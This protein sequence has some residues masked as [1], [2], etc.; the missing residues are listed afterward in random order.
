[1]LALLARVVSLA[2]LGGVLV[3]VAWLAHTGYRV[4]TDSFVTPITLSP[5]SDVVLQTKLSMS[6]LVAERLRISARLDEIRSDLRA[7]D[8]ASTQ[9]EALRATAA[10]ALDFATA[11]STRHADAGSADLRTLEQ[12]KAKLAEMIGRQ[13]IAVGRARANVRA[14]LSTQSDLDREVQTLDQLRV[15]LLENERT[16]VASVTVQ[17]DAASAKRSLTGKGAHAPTPEMLLQQDQLVKVQ[18]ELV[19]I[20]AER[21]ARQSEQRHLDEEFAKVDELLAQLKR[22]PV[23]RAMEAAT[24]VAFV[25]YTQ[26]DGVEAGA[27]VLDC[28]WALFACSA[29]GRIVELLPGEVIVPDP[30]GSPTRGQ[31]AIMEL[32]DARAAQSRFLRVRPDGALPERPIAPPATGAPGG[33]LSRN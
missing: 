19:K 20:E 21:R 25:P 14:G 18:L 15:A 30:W 33:V 17:R 5:D 23:Y 11:Q 29:A 2:A 13:E 10:R 4:A 1:V 26:I 16:Q 22:R 31:Y 32:A 27:S 12:Q 24:Q 6:Q 28:T 9:L 3:G 8:E 7:A